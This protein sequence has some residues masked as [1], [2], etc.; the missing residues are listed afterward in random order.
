MLL[1]ATDETKAAIVLLSVAANIISRHTAMVGVDRE[2]S[3][4]VTGQRTVRQV[5]VMQDPTLRY[6]GASFGYVGF[7]S[8]ALHIVH[9]L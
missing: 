5:P 4:R 6:V 2:R 3:D 9:A 8:V 1:D 7:S